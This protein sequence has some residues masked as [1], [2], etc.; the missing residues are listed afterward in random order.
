MELTKNQV[1][2]LNPDGRKSI[3]S[4][5]LASDRKFMRKHELEITTAPTNGE[6][7]LEKPVIPV[8]INKPENPV[9]AQM[10]QDLHDQ[11]F[12]KAKTDDE[13]TDENSL[14]SQ[15]GLSEL[16]NDLTVTEPVKE[17]KTKKS[18]K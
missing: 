13:D 4:A 15:S 16:G 6:H 17:T 3:I 8:S 2:V 1:W 9:N 5:K 12:G 14:L 7:I 18:T 10:G 11:L